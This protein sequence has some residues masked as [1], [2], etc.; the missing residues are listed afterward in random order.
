V[1]VSA[2][3][4]VRFAVALL[5]TN[6]RAAFALRGAFWMQATFML[7]NDF[8]FFVTW[9]I[10]FQRWDAI[11]GWRLREMAIL[12]GAV[13]GAYGV[14]VVLWRGIREISRLIADGGLDTFLTQPKDPLLHVMGSRSDASGWGDLAAALVLLGAAGCLAPAMLPVTIFAIACSAIVVAATGVL[15]HSSAFWADDLDTLPRQVNEFVLIFSSYPQTVYGPWL[16]LVL[17]TVIPAGFIGYL[18][19]EVLRAFSWREAAYLAGGAVLYATAAVAVFRA[20][21]RRYA[22]GNRTGLRA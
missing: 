9:W 8:I 13:A 4:T 17:F 3:T 2:R 1:N 21:L 14:T 22:S 19:V 5:G 11:G 16:R 7:V 15:I 10:F 6:L 12:Y 18:P 20:G